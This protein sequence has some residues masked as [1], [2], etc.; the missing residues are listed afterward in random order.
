MPKGTLADSG[1]Y[2]F[3]IVGKGGAARMAA[4]PFVRFQ[5]WVTWTIWVFRASRRIHSA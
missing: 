5:T 2:S 4:A 3:G 1:R